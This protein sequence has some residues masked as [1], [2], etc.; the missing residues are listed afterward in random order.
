MSGQRDAQAATVAAY[1]TYVDADDVSAL[2]DLFAPDAVYRRPGYEPIQGHAGLREFY[3][4]ERVIVSGRHQVQTMVI[5]SDTAAVSG[6]FEGE[7]RDGSSASLEFADF[8]TFDETGRFAS[9][10]TFF[11]APLV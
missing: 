8:Y 1:Y 10:Q 6:T 2:V 3:T 5:E 7:L 9:R 11:Y 4:G